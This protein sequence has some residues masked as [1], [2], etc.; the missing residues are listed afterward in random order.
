M[1]T[2]AKGTTLS[3]S[4]LLEQN[5]TGLRDRLDRSAFNRP[6]LEAARNFLGKFIVRNHQGRCISAAITEVEA[7]KGPR[8]R[9]AHT[10]GGRR[11][12]RVEPLYGDGGTVY[13]YLV[14]GMHWLLNFSTAGHSVPE[15][16]LIR[17]VF[18]GPAAEG[19]L[20]AGP[21]KVCR[22]LAIDKSLD[23][24]D[25]VLSRDLWLEDRGVRIPARRIRS[26]P[27]VGVDY[28]GPYWAARPWRFSIDVETIRVALT[29][30]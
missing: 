25:A 14:Y 30:H 8:D 26:G 1:P 13:V 17:G 3:E 15:G 29:A 21:G 10:H 9:A 27:R 12:P 7:Y 18:A 2:H 20:I 16:V 11:T 22:H 6:T 4:L 19:T 24:T 5:A 23:G 28:A